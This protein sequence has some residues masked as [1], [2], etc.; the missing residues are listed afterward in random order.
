MDWIGVKSWIT[1]ELLWCFYQLIGLSF[2]RHP[3]TAD[4]PLVSKLC[5]AKFLQ[6]CSGEQTHVH[7]GWPEGEYIF[8]KKIWGGKLFF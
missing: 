6:I 5:N 1:F 8:S 4:D 7:L 3:F 2:R